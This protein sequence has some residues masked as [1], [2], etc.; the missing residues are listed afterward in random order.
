MVRS[1]LK[2]TGMTL[3]GFEVFDE[4]AYFPLNRVTLLFGPN[5]SGKSA[6]ATGLQ[7]WLQAL[8]PEGV[9]APL[10]GQDSLGQSPAPFW[11]GSFEVGRSTAPGEMLSRTWR[12][13]GNGL[14]ADSLALALH[15]KRERPRSDVA[16]ENVDWKLDF[17]LPEGG[18][19]G[20][21]NPEVAFS[22]LVNG[23]KAFQ[24]SSDGFLSINTA[25][26]PD[27][28]REVK[29]VF[30]T[31]SEQRPDLASFEAGILELRGPLTLALWE[32]REGLS[33]EH[34]RLDELIEGLEELSDQQ[35][36]T[37][38]QLKRSVL[39]IWAGL[40]REFVQVGSSI[41]AGGRL[42]PASREV[43]APEALCVAV[44]A[45]GES[46]PLPSLLDGEG[47]LTALQRLV[48]SLGGGDSGRTGVLSGREGELG[49]EV[50][51]YLTGYL[52][53]DR[54]Y[55]LGVRRWSLA[56]EADGTDRA[57]SVQ[58]HVDPWIGQAMLFDKDANA[59]HFDEVGSG[60]GYV[61][62]VL[63][64]LA[65]CEELSLVQQPELHLHPAL[66]SELGDVV[67][68]ATRTKRSIS[69]VETHSEH[70]LLRILRRI[71]ET[72]AGRAPLTE[73]QVRP[74][75]VSVL[76]FDSQGDGRTV[77]RR[78]RIDEDG[79]FLDRWPGGFFDE[80]DKDLFDE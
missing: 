27:V 66:Q 41:V 51:R 68:D 21:A 37:L 32:Y 26:F 14:F 30:M 24:C 16:I 57:R 45:D 47:E 70:L 67:L 2:L 48:V 72:G 28:E 65:E 9:E 7:L 19:N 42:V 13:K 39:Q 18:G 33:L 62:P 56:Y 1:R 34:E 11:G 61:L 43:P 60:L 77:V 52:F 12:R 31:V 69:I 50:Q 74:E 80:R 78:L 25:F 29:E 44:P 3:A 17:H 6:L 46:V 54:G 71:R 79:E 4:P 63:V 36:N 58:R 55:R 23:G 40:T 53:R 8:W 64:A 10:L 38:K 22:Y 35:A 49:E 75:E 76:F 59:F 73:L 15:L 20:W 5:S